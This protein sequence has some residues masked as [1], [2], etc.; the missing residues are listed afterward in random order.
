MGTSYQ[1][2][3]VV[4]ELARVKDALAAAGVE[5]LVMPAGPGRTAVIPREGKFDYV[6]PARL[7]ELLSTRAGFAALSNDIVDSDLVRMRAFCDGRQIHEY[8][9]DQAMLV[10]WFIGDDGRTEF[11]LDGVEYPGDASYPRGPRGADPAAL[12]PFGVDPV[13]VNRL[14]A[15]LRGEFDGRRP[16]YA[17]FQHRL[18]LKAMNLDPRGLTTAFRWASLEDLPGAVRIQEGGPS[19]GTAPG[20]SNEQRLTVVVET[21]L[22]LESDPL[23]AAQVIADAVAGGPSP[24]RADVGYVAVIPGAS[25]SNELILMTMRLAAAPR[26]ATYFVALYA[27]SNAGVSGQSKLVATAEQLWATALRARYAL[28]DDQGPAVL[29]IAPEQFDIGFGAAQ[30]YRSSRRAT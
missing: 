18:I 16:V 20:A 25:A 24:M 8:V 3:V 2:L 13:D 17:E 4:G 15:A 30:G 21:G 29:L 26:H 27:D 9:S 11:R 1:T 6:N 28:R 12:A 10:D 7:A 22:P 5:G 19:V 14:G 23:D